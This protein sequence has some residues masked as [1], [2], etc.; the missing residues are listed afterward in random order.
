MVQKKGGI[1]SKSN[2]KTGI[3]IHY[4]ENLPISYVNHIGMMV[5]NA[6][7]TLD[8]GIRNIRQLNPGT[9]VVE[10]AIQINQRIMMSLQHAKVFAGKLNTLIENYEKDFGELILEPKITK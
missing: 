2:P 3:E 4:P 1:K 9:N 6:D 10:G 5:S 8:L 7:I